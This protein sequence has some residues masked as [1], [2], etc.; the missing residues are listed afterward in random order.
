[1]I[2]ILTPSS[3]ALPTTSELPPMPSRQNVPNDMKLLHWDSSD[4]GC[5]AC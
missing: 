2:H 1:M 4:L 5:S 3:I